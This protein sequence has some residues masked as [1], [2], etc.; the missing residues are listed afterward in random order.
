MVVLTSKYP[1]KVCRL[2]SVFGLFLTCLLGKTWAAQVRAI[3]RLL[4]G[5][6]FLNAE[7]VSANPDI[8]SKVNDTAGYWV[9]VT[10]VVDGDTF[11][12]DGVKYRLSN[13]DAPETSPDRRHGYKCDAERRLGELATIEA[14]AILLG[15][16]VWI[17]PSG[18]KG[19]Y[20]RPLVR[21]RYMRGKWFGPHMIEKR[22]AASNNPVTT[23]TL[24]NLPR[25]LD[26]STG[27]CHE[28]F[29]CASQ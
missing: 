9:T 17:K 6:L 18:R 13:I 2:L 11:W 10:E 16:K 5:I 12:A 27:R 20:G 29:G 22:L 8:T 28:L 23:A 15:R 24:M 25:W 7:C 4:V 3:F 21:V 26:D 19:R 1:F 14:E